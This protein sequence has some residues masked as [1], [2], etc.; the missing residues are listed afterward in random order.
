MAPLELKDHDEVLLMTV[1]AKA[2]RDERFCRDTGL[3]LPIVRCDAPR[4]HGTLG[5]RLFSAGPR[6]GGG[7]GSGGAKP[8]STAVCLSL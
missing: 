3:S 8:T 6:D 7:K 2:G 1:G 4:E 5:T